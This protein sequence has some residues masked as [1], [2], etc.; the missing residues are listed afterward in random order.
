MKKITFILLVSLISGTAF[1]QNED[2]AS[3]E[4]FAEIVEPLSITNVDNSQLRFGRII[5]S[6]DGGTVTIAETLD[7]NRD[8]SSTDLLAP[9]GVES[10]A[11][12]NISG[13]TYTYSVLLTPTDLTFQ[14]EATEGNTDALSLE[15]TPSFEANTGT[16]TIGANQAAGNYQG[17]VDVTV[18]YE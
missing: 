6:S 2:N 3:A 10:S 18:S 17:N 11:V 15:A 8:A 5:G 16:L 13:S 12:F 1:A 9:G 14:G 4:A 7:G